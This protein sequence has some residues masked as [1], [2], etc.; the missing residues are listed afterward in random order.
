[1]NDWGLL[2]WWGNHSHDSG[3][4]ELLSNV[5]TWADIPKALCSI[6]KQ[7]RVSQGIE[8]H[9]MI[10]S[11]LGF[12]RWLTVLVLALVL[13]ST[14]V[15]SSS[16]NCLTPLFYVL[17]CELKWF[18]LP[19]QVLPL[20]SFLQHRGITFMNVQQTTATLF[21]KVLVGNS[22]FFFLNVTWCTK[23][24]CVICAKWTDSQFSQFSQ[25]GFAKHTLY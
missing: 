12:N 1:M 11:S 16:I 23:T 14:G 7:M 20:L 15:S 21:S 6:Y 17:S 24:V 13:A 2:K 18:S 22:I 5:A 3:P 25:F 19:E 4:W 10:I 9:S 8:W